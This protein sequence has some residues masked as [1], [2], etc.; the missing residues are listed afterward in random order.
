VNQEDVMPGPILAAYDP[1]KEDRAPVDLALAAAGLTG[2]PVVAVAVAPTVMQT[3]WADPTPIETEIADVVE[4]ALDRLRADT[5]LETASVNGRSVPQALH[6]LASERNARLLVVGS[7]NRAATGRV[8]PGS[9]AERLLHGAPC[10]VALAPHGYRRAA[11]RTVGVGFTDTADGHA[12]LAAAHAL[13]RRAGAKLRV[14]AAV[15]ASGAADA[16][17]AEGTPPLRGVTLEGHHRAEHQA[18]MARAV[19]D[20]PPGVEIEQ[21]LHVDDPADV[22]VR[23]SQHVD[24]LVCGSRG[25]GPV[26]NLLLGGVSRRV[27][28][29]A[30]C[31]VLV[32]PRGVEPELEEI[33]GPVITDGATA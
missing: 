25:Y 9:T 24:V 3:G 2:T 12:A 27:V 8:L 32:L 18:A 19:N 31:P 22:L 13:A 5:G 6:E 14:I 15:H 7:T 23:V 29:G 4:S 21:E 30:Q 17:L 28:D 20:L 16:A 33:F 26:R 1:F 11:V 10:P